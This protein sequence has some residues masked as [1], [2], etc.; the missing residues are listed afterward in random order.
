MYL[1][2]LKTNKYEVQFWKTIWLK[3]KCSEY[4]S[5]ALLVLMLIKLFLQ[6]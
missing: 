5:N 6:C 2:P 1:F 4:K 3:F